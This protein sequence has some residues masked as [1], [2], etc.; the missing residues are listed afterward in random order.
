[1]QS[2][3][4]NMLPTAIGV[5]ISPLPIIAVILLLMS[6][7]P[8]LN[9]SAF[10]AGWVVG[11]A[12]VGIIILNIGISGTSGSDVNIAAEWVKLTFGLL[13]LAMAFSQW[14]S[15]PKQGQQPKFPKWMNAIGN[16]KWPLAL[17]LGFM[18]AALNPK[19]LG[20]TV[21]GVA[22]LAE[23]G[24]ATN[25]QYMLLFVFVIIGTLGL[26]LPL[27]YFIFAKQNAKTLLI[28]L[29]AWLAKYNAIIMAILLFVIG[30]KVTIEA[31]TV[32]IG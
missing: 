19:N 29:K 32:L 16:T 2:A 17:G 22:G 23:S 24:I 10:T 4:L 8:T 5:A 26:L 11:L 9:G 15:R 14:H 12:L 27:I 30:L 28:K 21:A 20:L 13:F 7:R 31:A 1:M 6:K 18:L 3:L 25:Q